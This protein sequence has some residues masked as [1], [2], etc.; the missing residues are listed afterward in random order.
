MMFLV[1]ERNIRTSLCGGAAAVLE[2]GAVDVTPDAVATAAAGVGAAV[3]L[4]A[5]TF[6]DGG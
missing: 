2:V 1:G 4:G 5:A 6:D 3:S